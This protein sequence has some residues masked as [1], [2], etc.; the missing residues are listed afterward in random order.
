MKKKKHPHRVH[1]RGFAVLEALI[2]IC[3]GA[4]QQRQHGH[5]RLPAAVVVGIARAVEDGNR[6]DRQC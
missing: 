5:A 1:E 2:G 4:Q 6:R 3:P